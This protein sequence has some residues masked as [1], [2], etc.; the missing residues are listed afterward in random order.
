MEISKINEFLKISSGSGYGYGKGYGF[1]SGYGYGSGLSYDNRFIK[2][3]KNHQVNLID[4]IP[5]IITNIKLNVAKGFILNDDFTLEPTYVVKGRN[6]FAHGKNL[7]EAREALSDKIIDKM[8][9]EDK[10]EEF[11]KHFNKSGLKKYSGH[12][13]FKW[14]NLLTGSCLQG[15]ENFVKNNKLDLDKAY[16]VQE[17]IELTKNAF[18]GKIIKR[19]EK[20]MFDY[21]K[22]EKNKKFY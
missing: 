10:I 3:F 5:T 22:E 7:R 1:G 12:E 9:I 16:S 13:F 19:L 17:F 8:N 15:R 6:M 11:K 2:K 4:D 18:G 14:H 20:I 21:D